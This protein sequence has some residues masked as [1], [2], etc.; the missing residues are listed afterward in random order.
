VNRGFAACG[1]GDVLSWINADDRYQPATFVAVAD[2][3]R[4]FHDVR[5][6]TGSTSI[7]AERGFDKGYLGR[8]L[9]PRK[10]I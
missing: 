2:I 3:L 7:I 6:V 4:Q 8:R 9:Y 5:W 1:E 10:A